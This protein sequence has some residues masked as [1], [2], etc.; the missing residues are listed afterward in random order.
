MTKKT[1]KQSN[2]FCYTVNNFTDEDI[3]AAMAMYEDDYNC[4]YTIIGFE[5][6]DR[7]E[8][9]HMQC[10]IYYTKKI[11]KGKFEKYILEHFDKNLH[12]EI[13][14][15]PKNVAAYC[16]CMEERK[17]YEMGDR[18]RQGHRTDLEVIKHDLLSGKPEKQIANEYFS[19]WCQYRRAFTE[20]RSLNDLDKFRLGKILMYTD[21]AGD[22]FYEKYCYMTRNYKVKLMTTESIYECYKISETREYDFVLYP[23]FFSPHHVRDRFTTLNEWFEENVIE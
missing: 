5:K 12:S 9:P 21:D 2:G 3:A 20:F 6:G 1:K 18:P 8:T 17:Y 10:Y 13:Q 19:Q 22:D 16:Y 4:K 11:T 7:E 14:C 23:R 15:S